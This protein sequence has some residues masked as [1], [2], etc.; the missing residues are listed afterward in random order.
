MPSPN[1]VPNCKDFEVANSHDIFLFCRCVQLNTIEEF[2][3][4]VSNYFLTT[5]KQVITCLISFCAVNGQVLIIINNYFILAFFGKYSV[6]LSCQYKSDLFLQRMHLYVCNKMKLF[7]S[8]DF[9]W[10]K[11]LLKLKKH[12]GAESNRSLQLNR[13]KMYFLMFWNVHFVYR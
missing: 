3:L 11:F 9:R 1:S 5:H 10:N 8:V 4:H 12:L 2:A 6:V 7:I 13:G